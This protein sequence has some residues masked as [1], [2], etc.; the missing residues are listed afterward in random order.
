MVQQLL[1]LFQAE[2]EGRYFEI[3]EL[4]GTGEMQIIL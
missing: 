1:L 3:E 4:L 2:I